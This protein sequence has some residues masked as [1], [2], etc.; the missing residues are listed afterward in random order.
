MPEWAN[1]RPDSPVA[2]KGL[3]N[4]ARVRRCLAHGE[5]QRRIRAQGIGAIAV[6]I[7]QRDPVKA[8]VHQGEQGVLDFRGVAP[9][10]KTPRQSSTQP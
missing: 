8:L 10:R 1:S 5:F 2:R 3:R 9:I 7:A 4:Q 6:F